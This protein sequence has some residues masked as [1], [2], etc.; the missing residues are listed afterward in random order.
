MSNLSQPRVLNSP[1]AISRLMALAQRSRDRIPF[2]REILGSID[3]RAADLSLSDLPLLDK[4]TVRQAGKTM[5]SPAFC[6]DGPDVSVAFTSGSTGIPLRLVRTKVEMEPSIRAYWRARAAIFPDV[7]N[8]TG[9]MVVLNAPLSER[10]SAQRGP[11]KLPMAWYRKREDYL[12]TLI[13]LQ[14]RWLAGP[15]AVLSLLVENMQRYKRRFR[16][17]LAFVESNS[18]YLGPEMRAR[19]AEF[20][21]CPVVNHYGCEE[22]FTIAYECPQGNMH[23]FDQCVVAELLPQ[24]DGYDYELVVSSLLFETMPFIRYRVGDS[25]QMEEKHCTCGNTAPLLGEV[26]GRTTELVAGSLFCGHYFFSF[27]MH[28]VLRQTGLHS[29]SRYQ[30]HQFTLTDFLVKLQLDDMVA[31]QK[32]EHFRII[33]TAFREEMAKRIPPWTFTFECVD[34]IA[35]T[36]RGKLEYF[37]RHI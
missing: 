23:L 33:S 9:I 4:S 15:P 32:A 18:D 17:R 37:I 3:F 34:L 35:L 12:D 30:I 27:V 10:T 14:P 1:S 19:L 2:Y 5:I 29:I 6:E 31:S 13:D 24:P 8:T 26:H 16:T 11:I 22:L 28:T 36:T 20:F 25:I 21:E 7:M